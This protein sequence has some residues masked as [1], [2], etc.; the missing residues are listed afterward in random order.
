M[1]N[2]IVVRPIPRPSASTAIRL[3]PGFFRSILTA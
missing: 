1:L 2:M 3:V